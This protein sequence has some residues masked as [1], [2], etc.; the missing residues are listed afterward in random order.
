MEM[1]TVPDAVPISKGFE[2][3]SSVEQEHNQ[4]PHCLL[5]VLHVSA[6]PY[7]Y[8]NYGFI[9]IEKDISDNDKL[10]MRVNDL[11]RENQSLKSRLSDA[12]N[13]INSCQ[14]KFNQ[15][16][17]LIKRLEAKID[18]QTSPGTEVG[19]NEMKVE[20]MDLQLRNNWVRYSSAEAKPEAIKIGNVV[21]LKGLLKN[22]TSNV[23]ANLPSGWRPAKFVR[24]VSAQGCTPYATQI[25]IQPN[26][27]IYQNSPWKYYLSLG[28]ISFPVNV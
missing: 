19:A 22:G 25:T 8:F 24:A 2:S 9:L 21:Y 15:L 7:I 18:G 23:I 5:L 20:K 17:G 14:Q 11:Q 16:F 6:P 13:M 3:E 28:G 26:G 4:A 10:V 12:E 27:D 1:K